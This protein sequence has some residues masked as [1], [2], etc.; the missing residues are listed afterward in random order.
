MELH[1]A[2][3]VQW[4]ASQCV[5]KQKLKDQ[6]EHKSRW[7]YLH[8]SVEF[9][10]CIKAAESLMT[11]LFVRTGLLCQKTTNSEVLEQVPREGM[12]SPSLEKFRT[13]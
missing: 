5:G 13:Y 10:W 2:R 1:N 8:F 9:W 7:D 12:D 3:T 4:P 6:L 11:I